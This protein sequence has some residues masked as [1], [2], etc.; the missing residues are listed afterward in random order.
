[1]SKDTISRIE[2]LLPWNHGFSRDHNGLPA[3]SAAVNAGAEQPAVDEEGA[4]R[5]NT[6]VA[7]EHKRHTMCYAAG[8]EIDR[9]EC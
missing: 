5:P 6:F 9:L 4:R 1:M 2:K 8:D 3:T 7:V